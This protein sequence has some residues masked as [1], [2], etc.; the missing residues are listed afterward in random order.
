MT[1][2]EKK[3]NQKWN[4]ILDKSDLNMNRGS[5]GDAEQRDAILEYLSESQHADPFLEDNLDRT[6]GNVLTVEPVLSGFQTSDDMKQLRKSFDGGDNFIAGGHAVRGGGSTNHA[7]RVANPPLWVNDALKV[8]ALLTK[9]FPLMVKS[10][11]QR[12]RAG[13]WARVIQLYYRMGL[14]RG[15][16]CKIMDVNLNVLNLILLR[17]E[18][19]VSN[20]PIVA[21]TDAVID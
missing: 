8:Q 1:A 10:K 2:K 4:Q 16:V 17:I 21:T 9:V 3:L 11:T 7:Q 20:E 19:N 14:T 13:R 6:V 12:E 5:A 18:K 15:R